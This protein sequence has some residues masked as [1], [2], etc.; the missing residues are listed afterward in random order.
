[1]GEHADMQFVLF[2]ECEEQTMI[3]RINKRAAEAGDNKR[4]DDDH[5][6]PK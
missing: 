3:D 4:N 5:I 2:L 6:I 1:M